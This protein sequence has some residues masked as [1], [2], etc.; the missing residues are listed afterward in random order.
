MNYRPVFISGCDCS[1]TIILGDMLG[2]TQWTVTTPESQFIHDMVIQLQMG[3]F[4]ST[5][6]AAIWLT[7]NVKFIAWDLLLDQNQLAKLID[8]QNP[9]HAI[10]NL[11]AA[12][13]LQTHSEKDKADVW[14]DHTNDSFKH[15]SVLKRLFPEARF[16]HVVRDGR[17]VCA[18]IKPLTWGPNNAF[19]ASRYWAERMEQALSVEVAEGDNCLR[20]HFEDLV[21]NPSVT[22]AEV[23]KF[24]DIPFSPTMLTGGGLKQPNSTQQVDDLCGKPAEIR[25]TNDWKNCLC[26][27]EIRDFESNPLSH[28]LLTNMNYSPVYE[29]PPQ[30]SATRILSRYGHHFLYYLY[31]GFHQRHNLKPTLPS[32]Y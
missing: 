11:V 17:A 8:L 12:Y 27:A 4:Q 28:D 9:S 20:I 15:H 26:Q 30:L 6:A 1:G 7:K 2:N 3:N 24:I 18:S 25:S 21:N 19:Q 16:I 5:Q 31:N 32:G 23:C 10:N 13:A 14:I 22:L 29:H